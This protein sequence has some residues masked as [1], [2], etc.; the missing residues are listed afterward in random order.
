MQEK[1]KNEGGAELGS[2]LSGQQDAD[3][4]DMESFHTCQIKEDCEKRG[5]QSMNYR[6]ARKDKSE[7]K[8]KS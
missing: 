7:T 4:T 8:F 2:I 5:N 6:F 3:V 1:N